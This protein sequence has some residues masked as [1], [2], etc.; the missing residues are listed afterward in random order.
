MKRIN[1]LA[2][3][4]EYYEWGIEYEDWVALMEDELDAVK[5]SAITGGQPVVRHVF[6]T[7][8]ATID[9]PKAA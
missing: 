9:A 6:T 7:E 8:W 1:S 2:I 4:E 3:E 5:T